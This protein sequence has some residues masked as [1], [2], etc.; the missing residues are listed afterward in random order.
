MK[1]NHWY[2]FINLVIN[3]TFLKLISTLTIY[4]IESSFRNFNNISTIVIQIML[5]LNSQTK[6]NLHLL[7]IS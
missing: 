5:F 1:D 4:D 6:I 7:D 2:N 3:I